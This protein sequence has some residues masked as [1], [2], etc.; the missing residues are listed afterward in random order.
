MA[1]NNISKEEK[2]KPVKVAKKVVA[3][4]TEKKVESKSEQRRKASLGKIKAPSGIKTDLHVFVKFN[5]EEYEIDTNDIATSILELKPPFIKT[6]VTFIISK[7]GFKTRDFII[8][9]ARAKRIFTSKLAAMGFANKIK[10]LFN[11]N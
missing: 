1:K 10:I 8:F 5:N 11:G 3:K 6:P 9:P 4:K 7:E 2:K